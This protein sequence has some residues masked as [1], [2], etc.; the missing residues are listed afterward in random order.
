MKKLYEK[1]YHPLNLIF[2][3]YNLYIWISFLILNLNLT[4]NKPNS[5]QTLIYIYILYICVLKNNLLL[6]PLLVAWN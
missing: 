4:N 1:V 6:M 3:T 2:L 5:Y